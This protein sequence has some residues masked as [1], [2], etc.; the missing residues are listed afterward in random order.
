VFLTKKFKERNHV[1]LL[2]HFLN[3]VIKNI[4][5]HKIADVIEISKCGT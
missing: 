2:K 1:T 5:I 3:A 4:K